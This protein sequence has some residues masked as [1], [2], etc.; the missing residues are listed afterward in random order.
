MSHLFFVHGT[1]VRQSGYEQTLKDIRNGLAKAGRPDVVVSGV[2]WGEAEGVRVT[3]QL[4]DKM[5]PPDGAAKGI[6]PTSPEEEAALW[7]QLLEDPL[8][9]LRIVALRGRPP[10]AALPGQAL[11][12]EAFKA[13]L[14]ALSLPAPAGGVDPGAVRKAALWLAEGEGA[15]TVTEAATA[16]GAVND[17]VLVEATARAIVALVLLDARGEPGEGPD[18]L[19]ISAER[20]AVVEQVEKGLSEGVMGL[21]DW[22]KNK[23][24]GWVLSRATSAGKNRRDGLMTAVSPGVGD[25]LLTQRRGDRVL[26]LLRSEIGKL[27]GPVAVIGHSLGGE[28]LVNLITSPDRPANITKLITAGSQ[29]S[30]FTACDSMETIRLGSPLPAD[31]PAWL[32][33]YDRND[34]L[35][36]CAERFFTG[37][38][39]V[40]DVEITSGVPFPDS[41]GAYWRQSAL[42]TRLAAF[43]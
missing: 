6:T 37:G 18:A 4:I 10:T 8:F 29:I 12:S 30:F 13:K 3:S 27:Q 25:I 22:L 38:K 35:G 28:H 23:V 2:S 41:H 5:L 40:T 36:Y 11:P 20:D 16:A 1:G 43:L 21:D 7:A 42:Y 19:F 34:F 33:F 17:P 39:G 14:R 31:F 24:K 26:D 15:P 32:N 9:E